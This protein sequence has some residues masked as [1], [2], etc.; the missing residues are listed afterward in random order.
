MA[1]PLKIDTGAIGLRD[2][3]RDLGREIGMR[4]NLYPKWIANRTIERDT[5]EFR[6]SCAEALYGFLKAHEERL[7][8]M[9]N[10]GPPPSTAKED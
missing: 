6:L 9:W 10:E 7:L 1:L 8:V 5:A 4:R 2:A 3:I